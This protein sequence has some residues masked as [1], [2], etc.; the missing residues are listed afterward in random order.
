MELL[1]DLMVREQLLNTLPARVCNW[2]SE[3]KPKTSAE[4]AG[5]AVDYVQARKQS[6]EQHWGRGTDSKTKARDGVMHLLWQS[7]PHRQVLQTTGGKNREVR[8]GRRWRRRI[9]PA[10]TLNGG[11]RG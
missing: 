9:V 11:C 5:Q 6:K 10:R 1:L 7:G 8:K 2:V 4:A 3:W